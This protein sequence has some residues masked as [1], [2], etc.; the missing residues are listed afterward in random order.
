MQPVL[1]SMDTQDSQN[2]AAMPKMQKPVLEQAPAAPIQKSLIQKR[3]I[4]PEQLKQTIP[5][6]IKGPLDNQVKY[7]PAK[8]ITAI[9]K[10]KPYRVLYIQNEYWFVSADWLPML[11]YSNYRH[12]IKTIHRD[13]RRNFYVNEPNGHPVRSTIHL[14]EMVRIVQANRNS[15]KQEFKNWI[16]TQVV[17]KFKKED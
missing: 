9:Y 13:F 11:G 1:L 6:G 5:A 4:M 8:L 16:M 3:Q 15:D 7:N 14:D 17:A 12:F 10:D 2:P